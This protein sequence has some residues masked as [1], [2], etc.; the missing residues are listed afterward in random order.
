MFPT[1]QLVKRGRRSYLYRP[2]GSRDDSWPPVVQR[3]FAQFFGTIQVLGKDNIQPDLLEVRL[4]GVKKKKNERNS[5]FLIDAV[6]GIIDKRAITPV[7]SVSL[8]EF[9]SFFL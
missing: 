6:Y 7:T 1:P 2:Y 3:T 8:I 5:S 4:A 9:Y